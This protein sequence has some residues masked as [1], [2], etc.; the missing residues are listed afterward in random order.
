MTALTNDLPDSLGLRLGVFPPQF[1][2]IV[3]SSN[4]P[5]AAAIVNAIQSARIGQPGR[6]FRDVGDIL[7]I[8][9]LTEQSPFLNWNDGIQASNG[10]SDEAYEEIPSQLLPLLRADSIGS[11]ASTSGPML[12]QFTGYDGH[13][14]AIEVSSDLKNWANISTNYPVNGMFGFTNSVSPKSK[15]QFYRSILLP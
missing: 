4:S 10:I 12:V 8:P 13:A 3:I 6:F 1:G 5:Q 15:S 14:Y 2:T 11:I 7:A 9:Q